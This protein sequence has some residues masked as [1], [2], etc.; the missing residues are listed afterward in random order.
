MDAARRVRARFSRRRRLPQR[1]S[2]RPARRDAA[3]RLELRRD[4]RAD[5]LFHAGTDARCTVRRRCASGTTTARPASGIFLDVHG[6]VRSG[7]DRIFR[8]PASSGRQRTSV[9][10]MPGWATSSARATCRCGL[11][12]KS[13]APRRS[14]GSTCCTGRK[15]ADRSPL[16]RGRSRP[17]CARA[18]AR[19]RVSRPR[20]RDVLAR[21]ADNHRQ[22]HRALCGGELSQSRAHRAGDGGRDRTCLEFGDDRQSR[23]HRPLARR[24]ARRYAR[25]RDQCRIGRR[26]ISPRLPTTRSRSTA[27][28]LA[29]RLSVYRLPEADWSRRVVA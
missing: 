5:L 14:S 21:Q 24:R 18:V 4:R 16:C 11:S 26:S 7:R 25:H 27:A 3:R 20:P 9:R 12:P 17:A 23:R 2:Q 13:S 6:V 29:D 15:C 19:R 8:R 22:S 28:V 10:A 1:R